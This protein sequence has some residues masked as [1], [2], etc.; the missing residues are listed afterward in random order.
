MVRLKQRRSETEPGTPCDHSKFPRS[1]AKAHGE[2][3]DVASTAGSLGR[4]VCPRL[5]FPTVRQPLPPLPLV[6][7]SD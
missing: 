7:A 4:D 2:R 3:G 6:G 5:S 1:G